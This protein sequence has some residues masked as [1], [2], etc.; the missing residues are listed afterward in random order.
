MSDKIVSIR[1][2]VRKPRHIG[3]GIPSINKAPKLRT[4]MAPPAVDR[5]Y[6]SVVVRTGNRNIEAQLARIASLV[7][8]LSELLDASQGTPAEI[9]HLPAAARLR[10]LKEAFAGEADLADRVLSDDDDDCDPQP[11]LDKERVDRMY[12]TLGPGA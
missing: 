2:G 9:F 4:A 8:E 10:H 6:G 12:Q 7:A 1:D 11:E 5:P 3:M